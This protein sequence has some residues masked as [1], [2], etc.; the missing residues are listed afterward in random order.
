MLHVRKHQTPPSQLSVAKDVKIGKAVTSLLA[1]RRAR[2]GKR[3]LPVG[4]GRPTGKELS[5]VEPLWGR[6]EQCLAPGGYV[7]TSTGHEY[8][9]GLLVVSATVKGFFK[10][11]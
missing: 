9:P 1:K 4:A 8:K 6:G 3:Q 7:K 11:W 5:S 10:L 2:R